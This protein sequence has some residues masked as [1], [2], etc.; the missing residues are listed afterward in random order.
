M[1]QSRNRNEQQVL[2]LLML[3]NSARLNTKQLAANADLVQR[4]EHTYTSIGDTCVEQTPS[5][6]STKSQ[7]CGP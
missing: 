3:T 4:E 7:S 1:R 6:A 2:W 5:P